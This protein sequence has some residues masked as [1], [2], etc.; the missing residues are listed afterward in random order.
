ME[1]LAPSTEEAPL[2]ARFWPL[3]VPDAI[4]V[5][6]QELTSQIPLE[7]IPEPILLELA[8]QWMGAFLKKAGREYKIIASLDGPREVADAIDSDQENKIRQELIEL[9]W[10]PP[11]ART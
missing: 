4:K 1:L 5:T 8:R 10:M 9:G 3:F 2:E 7:H 11:K 6:R